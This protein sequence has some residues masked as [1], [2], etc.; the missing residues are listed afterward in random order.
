MTLYITIYTDKIPPNSAG[1]ANGPIIRIRPEKKGDEG[2]LAHEIE[3]VRQWWCWI[4]LLGLPHSLLYLLSKRYRQWSE[5]TAYRIQLEYPHPKYTV[6]ERREMYATWL[7]IPDNIQGY[8]LIITK[9]E[10]VKLLS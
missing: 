2:L 8:G 6:E 1:C 3:H 5:V 10:A 4:P 7:S 9:E